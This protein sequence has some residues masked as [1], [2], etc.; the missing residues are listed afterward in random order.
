MSNQCQFV[1]N[2]ACLFAFTLTTSVL[3]ASAG[4]K[5]TTEDLLRLA[6]ANAGECYAVKPPANI[7]GGP[8][9]LFA[10]RSFG[11]ALTVR[12]PVPADGYYSVSSLGLFG[13]KAVNR[14]GRFVMSAGDVKFPG[15]YLGWYKTP[16][17]PPYLLREINW[18][19]AYLS[20]PGVDLSLE[21]VGVAGR[22]LVLADL[23]L[24]P[25]S[26]DGLK[27]KERDRKVPAAPAAIAA[28]AATVTPLPVVDMESL[29]G[30]KR[31]GQVVPPPLP[32]KEQPVNRDTYMKWIEDSGHLSYADNPTKHGQ[33][34]PR[35]LLPVLAKYVQSKEPRYGQACI[36]M[37]QNYNQWLRAE[38]AKKGWHQEYTANPNLIGVYARHL[39]QGGLLNPQKDQ[40]F[41]DMIL[42]M[43]RNVHVWNDPNTF[44]R[45]PMHRAQG[46]GMMKLIAATWY[47]DAP[48]A[49]EWKAYSEKVWGDFW[50]Y[51]DNPAADT[52][53]YNAILF[54]LV[55]GSEILGR[56][57]FFSDPQMRET[58]ERMMWEVTPDGAICPYGAAKGWNSSQGQ[59]LWM[60]ELL[61]ARTGD[62]RYRFAAHKLMNNMLY[63][64][65]L[66]LAP[67]GGIDGR[68]STEHVAVA[69]LL[70][71]DTIKPVEP[72]AGS[73][74]LYRKE[75]LRLRGKDA[76]AKYLK[77]LDPRPDRANICCG[78]IVTDKT[79]PAKLVL[80]SGWNP[81]D[82]FA[83]VDLF[84]RHDPVVVPGVLGMTRWGAP[85]TQT[86]ISKGPSDEN[87]LGLVVEDLGGTA[88][89]RF[90]TDP[91]LADKYYQHVQIADFHDLRTATFA[92]VTVSNYQGFPIQATREFL[93]IK[94]RFLVARDIPEFQ[95][96]FLTEVGP[97]WNTQN[98]GPQIGAT[99]ANTFFTGPQ[100]G[101]TILH[102]PP[103]D[104]LVYFTP[105]P[106]CR[107]KVLDHAANKSK[108]EPMRYSQLRY[109]WRGETQPGQKLLFTQ[110]YY[111]HAPTLQ[112]SAGADG[113]HV[114]LDTLETTVL[115]FTFDPDRREWVVS[116]QGG[117]TITAGDLSTDARY[118][119]L[120]TVKGDVKSISAVAGTF[121]TLKGEDVF[122]QAE[123]KNFEK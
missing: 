86:F 61:A 48:E 100:C 60:L 21:P 64:Q 101:N 6:R 28:P 63:Q 42:F 5:L 103:Q 67:R 8:E 109:S 96:G 108:T 74:I 56:Q 46:E 77:D 120:D 31:Y 2:V 30:N 53:Y 26:A 87:R 36:A 51:R 118:L 85:L 23:K 92:T 52:G 115:E 9:R 83:L 54:P 3:A 47:P 69:Y 57:E 41:K 59:R 10:W 89:L 62:G 105:Q 27:P 75:T 15:E 122:R 17:N 34:G 16:P 94:N 4:T 82:F 70:A 43:N 29:R 98:V 119:Y 116:N 93:F 14:L 39:S 113:I 90:N 71:D 65:D 50:P 55:L 106:G 40:W 20:A 76:A 123:R 66:Y 80:R 95:E 112:G 22:L 72:E 37:L 107:L 7:T 13:P 91:D 25:R 110:V 49:V 32:W 88:P 121:A 58:L 24:Q 99:W 38:V 12:V 35:H 84:P 114:L 1:R 111:P 102:T 81:G 117:K 104:L 97:A 11:G 78:L 68:F 44:W 19:V 79:M 18:G 33:Y 45:G 73:R